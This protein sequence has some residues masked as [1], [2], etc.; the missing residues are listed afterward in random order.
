MLIKSWLSE[1]PKQFVLDSRHSSEGSVGW[2]AH[3]ECLKDLKVVMARFDLFGHIGIIEKNNCFFFHFKCR[4]TESEKKWGRA[5]DIDWPFISWFTSQMHAAAWLGQADSR[6]PEH[7]RHLTWV[8]GAQII[9]SFSAAFM[10][11]VAWSWIRSR[12]AR[13]SGVSVKVGGL[14]L[15]LQCQLQHKVVKLKVLRWCSVNLLSIDEETVQ[16]GQKG[17]Q[18]HMTHL[19]E[20]TSGIQVSWLCSGVSFLYTGLPSES[21]KTLCGVGAWP[22]AA[23]AK[24][25]R[26]KRCQLWVMKIRSP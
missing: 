10:G 15:E 17:V 8:V 24:V 6:S 4:V 5:G 19:C 25:L 18:R 21:K 26:Q 9:G 14:T 13:K 2:H 1:S 11:A 23:G 20:T 7:H 12:T 22:P 3:R 16:G